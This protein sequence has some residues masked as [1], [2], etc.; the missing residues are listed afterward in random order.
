LFVL[1]IVAG[2]IQKL[3]AMRV[4]C[5]SKLDDQV[6]AQVIAAFNSL[7]VRAGLEA[8]VRVDINLPL[9]LQLP[10]PACQKI[11]GQ[12]ETITATAQTEL[13][14]AQLHQDSSYLW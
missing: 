2:L 7:A 11:Y 9:E 6:T 12:I 5:I 3:Y 8:K 13:K 10:Q 1:S 14:R 4:E